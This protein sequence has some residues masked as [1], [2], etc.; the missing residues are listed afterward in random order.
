MTDL[1]ML[2]EFEITTAPTVRITEGGTAGVIT[3]FSSDGIP[4]ALSAQRWVLERL[5]DQIA[6]ELEREPKPARGQ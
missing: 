4:I 5:R 6:R 3:C 1:K 2:Q